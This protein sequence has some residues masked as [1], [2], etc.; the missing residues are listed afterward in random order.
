[1]KHRN[2]SEFLILT[3]SNRVLLTFLWMCQH[4]EKKR[5]MSPSPQNNRAGKNPED[6]NKPGMFL[7]TGIVCLPY[8]DT[9]APSLWSLIMDVERNLIQQAG[10][11]V[12]KDKDHELRFEVQPLCRLWSTFQCRHTCLVQLYNCTIVYIIYPLYNCTIVY[13]IYPSECERE[14]CWQMKKKICSIFWYAFMMYLTMEMSGN[15]LSLIFHDLAE[16]GRAYM[17]VF[18]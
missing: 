17:G 1:M 2:C 15:T 11:K 6:L 12:H 18:R 13:I 4:Q 5:W 16:G 9:G 8:I 3:F 14:Q 10:L 7:V